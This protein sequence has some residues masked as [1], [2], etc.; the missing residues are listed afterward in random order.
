[1]IEGLLPDILPFGHGRPL[2]ERRPVRLKCVAHVCANPKSGWA[3]PRA[4][5][6]FHDDVQFLNHV[7]GLQTMPQFFPNTAAFDDK[8]IRDGT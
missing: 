5:H 6:P 7:S 4:A 3:F 8:T 2:D 1:M